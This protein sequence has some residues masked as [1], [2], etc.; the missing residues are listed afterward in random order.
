[1]NKNATWEDDVTFPAIKVTWSYE[2]HSDDPAIAING[3][4]SR[5]SSANKF[6]LKNIGS[7]T[8][9]GIKA[10]MAD[11]SEADPFSSGSWSVNEAKTELT[12]NGTKAPFGPAA[13]GNTRGIGL[14][15]SDET[16]IKVTFTVSE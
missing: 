1:M 15:L 2:E 4:Y 6:T 11:G 5:A 8:I 3:T 13:V 16:E 9:T 10:Y 7:L 12:V 14:I